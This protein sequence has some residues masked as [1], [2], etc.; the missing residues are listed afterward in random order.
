MGTRHHSINLLLGFLAG[1]SGLSCHP[2]T[3]HVS[4]ASQ[5]HP[6]LRGKSADELAGL[7][8][9]KAKSGPINISAM[10]WDR[11]Y[12]DAY[13]GRRATRKGWPQALLQKKIA[14]WVEQYLAGKTSFR[15]RLEIL[16]RPLTVAG[17]DPLM[18][19]DAWQWRLTD[20]SGRTRQ[21]SLAQTDT[22]QMFRG[23][24]GRYNWR[25]LGNVTFTGRPDA[26]KIRWLELI[27]LPPGD[28]PPIRLPR[29]HVSQ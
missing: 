9:R 26:S 1:L 4:Q 29:W 15:I 2:V 8:T 5:T 3:I 11:S 27:A 24:Q 18:E 14:D 17:K 20:S 28:H 22:K 16:N 21:A 13:L 25:V 6:T 19:L 7:F 23:T 12:V 10:L